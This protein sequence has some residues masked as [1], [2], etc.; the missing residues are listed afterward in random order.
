M[1]LH[2][3]KDLRWRT[4]GDSLLD[5]NEL[6]HDSFDDALK[7]FDGLRKLSPVYPEEYSYPDI[8]VIKADLLIQN[9]ELAFWTWRN[10]P[11]SRDY[12]YDTFKEYILPYRSLYEP[13]EQGWREEYMM[14]M[15]IN[16]HRQDPLKILSMFYKPSKRKLPPIVSLHRG[17][18]RYL[19]LGPRML[20]F[21]KQEFALIWPTPCCFRVEPPASR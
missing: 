2:Q 15:D 11:W 21:R 17:R 14:A 12:D 9:I 8:R 6:D 16:L 20:R 18:N 5:Y 3:S 4:E 19:F 1:P 13:L 10:R 7:V